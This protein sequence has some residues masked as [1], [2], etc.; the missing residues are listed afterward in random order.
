[1]PPERAREFET[2]FD[3]LSR[4]PQVPMTG[5]LLIRCWVEQQFSVRRSTCWKVLLGLFSAGSH[6]FAKN[7]K[8]PRCCIPSGKDPRNAALLDCVCL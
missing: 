7:L 3:T 4:S 6:C 1:M 2:G 8:G 5:A